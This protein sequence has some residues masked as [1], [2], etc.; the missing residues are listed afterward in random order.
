LVEVSFYHLER[1]TLEQAL[2]K[3]LEKVLERGLR[4]VVQA[5]TDERVEALNT[6]LWTY[7]QGSFLPHGTAADGHPERQPIFLTPHDENPNA[8]GVLVLVDN[9]DSRSIDAFQRVLDLF[10]GR[11][12][13]SVSAAR[14]RWSDRRTAGHD[15]TY[16]QQTAQGGWERKA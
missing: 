1:A 16:W 10:D 2:P 12:E 3:L 7:E 5:G 11:D 14:R 4:A 13:E 15:V 9:V 6:A 8:A